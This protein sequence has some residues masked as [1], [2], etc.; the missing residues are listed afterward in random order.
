[1]ESDAVLASSKLIQ[2]LS[3]LHCV[4]ASRAHWELEVGCSVLDVRC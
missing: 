2:T 1:M 3:A 4:T